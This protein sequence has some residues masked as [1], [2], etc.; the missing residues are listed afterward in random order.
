MPR[1]LLAACAVLGLTG[2]APA[3][4]ARDLFNG[5]NLD[6][7]V[8]DG[9]AVDRDG[10]P[11]WSVR[12]GMIVATGKVFGFLRYDRQT[13]GDFALHV[14]YRFTPATG[15]DRGNSGLGIRTGPFDAKRS[16]ATRASYAAY[17]VQLFDDA[18][19]PPDVHSTGSLYRYAAPTAN[20]VKPAPEWNTIEVECVGP[21][22][23]VTIN[24][25]TVLTA[26]QTKLADIPGKP[27][28]APAPADKLLRG[29]VALQSHSGEVAF[30]K[31]QIRE[32]GAVPPPMP[33]LRVSDNRR[34]LVKDDG[35]PFFWLGDTAWE[36][37]HRLNREDA[38]RYLRNRAAKKFTVIQA[39]ALAELDGLH[40]PNAY[41][42]TPLIDD[43]PAKPNEDYF[44]HVDW[45]VNKAG[46]YGLFVG[47]LPTW[48]DKWNR[49]RGGAG[50]EIFTP[51]NAGPYGEW[52]GRRYRDKPVIWI[53]GGDRAVE[54][55]RH[56]AVLRAMARG[57]RAGDGGAH[58]IT[59][60]P[61]GGGGSAQDF[62]GEDWLDLNLRQNGHQAE[63]TGRY[64]QTRADYDRTPVKPV[65]DGEPLYEDHPLSFRAKD[66][67]HSVAADV[68]RPLYWDLF[69]GACGHTY[70]HHSVWQMYTP[71]RKPINGPLMP[72]AD[73]LD[74]PGAGQMRHARA[75]LESRP[76]LTRV[77]DDSVLVPAAVPTAVPGAG[78]RRYAATR[79]AAGSYALVY[80]PVGRPF[81]VRM[82]VISGPRVRAWWFNPRDGS[83][84]AIGTY[85]NRGTRRFDPPDR[86]EELDWVLVLDDASRDFPPPGQAA[87]KPVAVE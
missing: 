14:E 80:A 61:R 8:V 58:L 74:Q 33:R 82:D 24:G 52:L 69:S 54:N 23:K 38:E 5:Q 63:Y 81:T 37:F 10:K 16:A 35:T 13:F 79:D 62:H 75:L 18:G 68:R 72:W 21:R 6:G 85:A 31:V 83:A 15:R 43:D 84:R 60:H 40:T 64:D 12:D 66:L 77:P 11:V 59:F 86:G 19:K 46:E 49:G 1:T 45:V 26:D 32:I 22:F 76:F 7:W 17:E 25:Q 30:R 73:A 29:Y 53:L 9:P 47:L 65:L 27:A 36:L 41:G 28:G 44:R 2:A 56:R 70:G 48:G 4:D 51:E 67:G 3:G 71:D 20:P 78:T 42:H 87:A 57:L 50:P 34:F 39:V 55:D